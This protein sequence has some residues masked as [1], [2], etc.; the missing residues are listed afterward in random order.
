MVVLSIHIFPV[1]NSHERS[2][3]AFIVA[4]SLLNNIVETMLNNIHGSTMLRKHDNDVFQALLGQQPCNNDSWNF[5]SAV[6][7][8]TRNNRELKIYDAAFKM[9]KKQCKFKLL[10]EVTVNWLRIWYFDLVLWPPRCYSSAK[11]IVVTEL[12][13]T[14]RNSSQISASS[15]RLKT[16]KCWEW[17]CFQNEV[18]CWEY[19]WDYKVF[20]LFVLHE[21]CFYFE[22]RVVELPRRRS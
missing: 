5:Y 21:E 9:L 14:L 2:Q 19:S 12:K 11:T 16:W 17:R 6:I 8:C 20:I 22:G 10:K 3:R 15:C 18:G 1:S 7:A 4:S 13:S